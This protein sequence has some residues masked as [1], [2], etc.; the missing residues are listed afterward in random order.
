MVLKLGQLSRRQAVCCQGASAVPVKSKS[1][2]R[3]IS[4][5]W[6]IQKLAR[7]STWWRLIKRTRRWLNLSMEM[8]SNPM[9]EHLMWAGCIRVLVALKML[10]ARQSQLGELK[11]LCVY[12]NIYDF[13]WMNLLW[14]TQWM[15]V[16]VKITKIFKRVSWVFSKRRV[17]QIIDDFFL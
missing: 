8:K 4:L 13:P 17:F 10:S 3:H 12:Q 1:A 7:P 2:A 14:D 6:E 5:W 11:A 9:M 15:H 16:S